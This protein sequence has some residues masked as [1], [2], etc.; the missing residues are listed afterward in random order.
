MGSKISITET[1][2]ITVAPGVKV[3]RD[4]TEDD[5]KPKDGE[6]VKEKLTIEK[7]NDSDD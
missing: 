2:E 4:T 7:R 6:V 1:E 3:V 5:P